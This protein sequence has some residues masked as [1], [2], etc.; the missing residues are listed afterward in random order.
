MLAYGLAARALT[1]PPSLACVALVPVACCEALN[2]QPTQRPLQDGTNAGERL[3]PAL[4]KRAQDKPVYDTAP[5]FVAWPPEGAGALQIGHG[6][7]L[8][9]MSTHPQPQERVLLALSGPGSTC[10]TQPRPLATRRSQRRA[11]PHSASLAPATGTGVPG[12]RTTQLPEARDSGD[13]CSP[14]DSSDGGRAAAAPI[15]PRTIYVAAR[16]RA[17]LESAG[18]I[19]QEG[20]ATS[21]ENW[22]MLGIYTW[23]GRTPT[24]SHHDFPTGFFIGVLTSS[25]ASLRAGQ[26]RSPASSSDQPLE[27]DNHPIVHTLFVF[28]KLLVHVVDHWVCR[29][30]PKSSHIWPFGADGR[31]MAMTR[32]PQPA[33]DAIVTVP[34]GRFPVAD[35]G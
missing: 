14:V 7:G 5:P 12:A 23:E 31:D 34:D 1:P 22:W 30:W 15:A 32:H 27:S 16:Q 35:T 4:P 6:M 8:S 33:V 24:R 18:A 10:Y 9:P 11:A 13:L 2:A 25:P 29:S 28:G 20:P 26:S 3:L 21:F 19:N 17:C